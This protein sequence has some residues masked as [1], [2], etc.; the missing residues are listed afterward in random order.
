[1]GG[2]QEWGGGEAGRW[3]AQAIS[4][5]GRL[6]AGSR[7]TLHVCPGCQHRLAAANERLS[8]PR[9]EKVKG[10]FSY[11]KASKLLQPGPC[12]RH[13]GKGSQASE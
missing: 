13:R 11:V 3:A 6:Q 1:M 2:K 5:V 12:R 10:P 4:H 7:Q 8:P 9:M